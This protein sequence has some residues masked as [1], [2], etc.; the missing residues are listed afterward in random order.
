MAGHQPDR[1]LLAARIQGFGNVN[2]PPLEEETGA[3]L[4]KKAVGRIGDMLGEE[5]M[6]TVEDFKEKGAVGAVKDAVADAGDIL[7]D[8]VSGIVGWLRGDAPVEDESESQEAATKALSNGPGGAAY[9]IQQASPT[10]GINAVWVMPEEADPA[11]LAQLAS[12]GGLAAQ[13]TD[14][15]VPKGIQPYQAPPSAPS[16]QPAPGF[17]SPYQLPGGPVIAPYQ[18]AP[19]GPP[20]YS[21]RGGAP[22][23]VGAPGAFN[24]AAFNP[25]AANQWGP[26]G[27]GPGSAPGGGLGPGAGAGASSTASGAKSLVERIAKGEVLVGPD[28]TKRLISQ[29]SAAKMSSKQ[30]AEVISERCRR[31]YLGLDGGDPADADASLARLLSLADALA[32]QGSAFTKEVVQQLSSSV[33]EELLSLRSSA[34]HKDAAEPMLRRL[35]FLPGGAGAAAGAAAQEAD[36]LGG[37][38]AASNAAPAAQADLLGGDDSAKPVA[39][40]AASDL[41]G[42]DMLGNSAAAPAASSSSSGLQA[43]MFSGQA[44]ATSSSAPAPSATA[45]PATFDPLLGG[46]GGASANAGTTASGLLGGLTLDGASAVPAAGASPLGQAKVTSPM[47][48]MGGGSA[49]VMLD[50]AEKAAGKKKSDDAFGFVGAEIAKAKGT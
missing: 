49:T 7:I 24:P 40:T 2:P 38:S 23:Y 26:G 30:L 34:K 25:A 20:G 35:G 13:Q 28:V 17:P 6:L 10:G 42:V 33:S 4:A 43:D 16:R 14:P 19:A 46:G 41:L 29:C 48:P 12:Q 44:L 47:A 31:L 18:P 27:Y 32:Q 3:V 21:G 50:V 37:G 8:G 36:L 11:A 9:G 1:A 22:P 15:R 39:S 5:V 45:T